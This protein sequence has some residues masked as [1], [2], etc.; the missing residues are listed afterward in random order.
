MCLTTNWDLAGAEPSQSQGH[1][2]VRVLKEMHGL[3][4][5]EGTMNLDRGN[6]SDGSWGNI[7]GM[8]P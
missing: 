5:A 6:S 2:W 8:L 7:S 4:Q 1:Q 3:E